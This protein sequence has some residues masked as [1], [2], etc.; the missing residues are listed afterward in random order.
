M[1]DQYTFIENKTS[2]NDDES[3]GIKDPSYSWASPS[4]EILERILLDEKS[5]LVN[6]TGNGVDLFF[7]NINSKINKNI[8]LVGS[9]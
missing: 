6:W 2:K 9:L 4:M 3:M 1:K 7:I 8:N 5:N